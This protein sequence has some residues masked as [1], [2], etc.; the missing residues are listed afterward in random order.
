MDKKILIITPYFAP[1][2]HAAVFRAYKLAK[3][4]PQF[5]WKPYVVTV[6]KNYNYNEDPTLLR[7]LPPEVEVHTARY[8][9]PTLRG[10]RMAIGGR[11]RSFKEISRRV[12]SS[13]S[14]PDKNQ[15]YR[16]WV[17]LYNHLLQKWIFVPDA[18]WTWERSTIH[19]AKELIR[20]NDIKLIFTSADPYTSHKIGFTLKKAGCKWVADLRDP[21]TYCLHMHS[22]YKRVFWRQRKA[23]YNA[24]L[25][26]DA[27]TVTSSA[28]GIILTDMYGVARRDKIHFIPTGLD[29]ALVGNDQKTDTNPDLDVP[30]L[31]FTGEYLSD[32]GDIF[33]RCFAE[34]MKEA[35]TATKYKL[36]FAGR[37]E[38]NEPILRPIIR[39][40]N[41]EKEVVMIDHVPQQE[42]YALIQNSAAGILCPG[43]ETF[44]W[45]LYAK[46]VDYIAL[47][48]PVIALV[49]DPS[50][51]RTRLNETGLGIFLDG[52]I[53][54]CARKLAQF[55][56]NTLPPVIPNEEACDRYTA[57][58][59]TEEFV[60]VF[61]RL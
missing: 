5:G 3:Y 16:I 30:Y 9:E 48:K 55:I 49:P 44:W 28:I 36:V 25:N 38:V 17:Q 26:A 56:S 53:D 50:E 32:Y 8:I 47:K 34:A 6:D 10:L 21:H 33:L 39:A 37:K 14:L 31:I 35:N 12:D 60:K 7:D 13:M 41:L 45:C 29:F 42:L 23:E 61:E 57:T 1:Q 58:R 2:S 51:A 40:L 4:L 20:E 54:V 19:E 24:V 18:Y 46:M 15:S 27:V 22:K 59:Q 11:D 52:N 43:P